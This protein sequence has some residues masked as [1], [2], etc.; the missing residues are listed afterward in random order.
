MQQPMV[1]RQSA[2]I[3]P[4]VPTP[5]PPPAPVGSLCPVAGSTPVPIPILP[6]AVAE[7]GAVA[8][9][10]M[11]SG[12]LCGHDGC[13]GFG[14]GGPLRDGICIHTQGE[15]VRREVNRFARGGKHA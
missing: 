13:D 3:G 12:R 7:T 14:I 1:V 10:E 15:I 6:M 8:A 2:E 4:P 11:Q 9:A 5:T